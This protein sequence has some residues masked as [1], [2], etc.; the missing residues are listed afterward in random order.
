MRTLLLL[1]SLP[2]CAFVSDAQFEEWRDEID[3]DGDG[4]P[5][6]EDCDDTN[7]GL[8][9][10]LDEIPYDGLDQDCDGV[11]LLDQDGDGQAGIERADW[12]GEANGFV[13]PGSFTEIDCDDLDPTVS[14]DV[15][16]DP[17]YDGV[18]SDCDRDNDF[19]VDG[20][21]Y[22][23]RGFEQADLD[24]F[25]A[26]SPFID[27]ADIVILGFD[28]CN[29]QLDSVFPGAEDVPRNG[30]DENCD[31][32]DD[33]DT[34]GD[35][36]YALGL[37]PSAYAA[38]C[39]LYPDSCQPGTL[40]GDC[41]DDADTTYPGAPIIPGDG[42]D[43]NCDGNAI[44]ADQDGYDDCQFT[45]ATLCDCDDGDPD[46]NPAR[47]E[48]LGDGVD[49]DCG[50]DGDGARW[51]FTPELWES[52]A[53]PGV[54]ATPDGWAVGIASLGDSASGQLNSAR[55]LLFTTPSPI[56]SYDDRY[57]ISLPVRVPG[58]D[59][60]AV[61]VGSTAY[62]AMSGYQ[63]GN[64]FIELGVVD[65]A[66]TPLPLFTDLTHLPVG[67]DPEL[68]SID[69]QAGPAGEVWA[70]GC[71]GDTA[72]VRQLS[73]AT[74]DL[75]TIPA[76]G[77]ACTLDMGAGVRLESCD[78]AGCQ[79]QD[80]DSAGNPS[81]A[82]SRWPDLDVDTVSQRDGM[83]VF[84][85]ASGGVLFDDGASTLDLFGTQPVLSVDV[86]GVGPGDI[87]LA[88]VFGGADP[89]LSLYTGAPGSLSETR[90]PDDPGG[91]APMAVGVDYEAGLIGVFATFDSSA[92]TAD[93]VGSAWLS[94]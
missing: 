72:L 94:Y 82:T 21:G 52:P 15:L 18:D 42:V 64:T 73:G 62:V 14:P 71:F 39:A 1:L 53:Q 22:V 23:A 47:F 88:A 56:A 81:P 5:F 68:R 12:P 80:L 57:S 10:I 30:H 11:D 79:A 87:V 34:D 67:F 28:D 8:A 36:Y 61:A 41:D 51:S 77:S 2:G 27:P 91:R 63:G 48:V 33:Y 43:N 16:S 17:P 76:I 37:D 55:V 19:D 4:S 90:M 13:W 35:G 86:A 49:D 70:A 75:Y 78:G 46:V 32:V 7:P 26:R 92:P 44:D 60:D 40:P 58:P 69:I 89:H 74:D 50:L 20:D 59:V 29:D 25:F 83:W 3:Q 6:S 85:L 66:A 31:D 45:I 54:A 24:A 9:P 38:Y 93:G 84:S 65:F